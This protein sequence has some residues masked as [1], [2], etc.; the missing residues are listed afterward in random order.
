MFENLTR[1]KT[2]INSNN[3][4]LTMKCID[5]KLLHWPYYAFPY[6]P[7]NNVGNTEILSSMSSQ[8]RL[9]K[10]IKSVF[11]DIQQKLFSLN[12]GDINVGQYFKTEQKCKK[13]ISHLIAQCDKLDYGLTQINEIEDLFLAAILCNNVAQFS[14]CPSFYDHPFRRLK[15]P[16]HQQSFPTLNEL[17]EKLFKVSGHKLLMKSH[18]TLGAMKFVKNVASFT[19]HCP[20]RKNPRY[21]T[22]NFNKFFQSS[23]SFLKGKDKR[24]QTVCYRFL[25]SLGVVYLRNSELTNYQ[26]ELEF[27]HSM[28]KLSKAHDNPENLLQ[29]IF[30]TQYREGFEYHQ[31]T[32]PRNVVMNQVAW[33][34]EESLMEIYKNEEIDCFNLEKIYLTSA[35]ALNQKGY[36][37]SCTSLLSTLMTNKKQLQ[38]ILRKKNLN[39]VQILQT[40]FPKIAD[41]E[42]L[43]LSENG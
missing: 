17:E 24:M 10:L 23:K 22:L 20:I 25:A 30:S 13:K 3:L 41:L 4:N 26:N 18:W 14:M 21:Y 11:N 40:Y 38:K 5:P 12:S 6:T 42:C 34:V 19:R 7:I 28:K 37:D 15:S 32:L 16:L 43:Q 36:V 27:S 8:R 29:K 31:N 39:W 33:Y 2:V 9:Q 1:K 35:Y